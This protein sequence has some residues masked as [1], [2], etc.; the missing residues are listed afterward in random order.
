[1]PRERRSWEKC[2]LNSTSP[3]SPPLGVLAKKKLL[4]IHRALSVESQD[5]GVRIYPRAAGFMDSETESLSHTPKAL[6]TPAGNT[7]NTRQSF[8]AWTILPKE[9]DHGKPWDGRDPQES[10]PPTPGPTQ[11]Q[12]CDDLRYLS[13]LWGPK[14]DSS[15][16]QHLEFHFFHVQPAAAVKV[17]LDPQSPG[18]SSGLQPSSRGRVP[19]LN[20]PPITHY[21]LTPAAGPSS[22][23]QH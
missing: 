22:W 3:I 17:K 21:T 23:P 11:Q 6:L 2:C 5:Q 18:N 14:T 19:H 20:L 16:L 8:P 9:H 15:A 1:M 12:E 4:V 13:C 7:R 10:S